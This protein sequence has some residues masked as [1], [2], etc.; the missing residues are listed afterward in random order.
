MYFEN[1]KV[2]CGHWKNKADYKQ[3]KSSKEK[4]VEETIHV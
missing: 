3:E 1:G 2:G 4:K